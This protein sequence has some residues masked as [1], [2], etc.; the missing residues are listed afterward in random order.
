ME[1]TIIVYIISFLAYFLTRYYETVSFDFIHSYIWNPA[2]KD[3]IGISKKIDYYNC[4]FRT[5]FILDTSNT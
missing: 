5:Y 2:Y 1:K 3:T 4:V